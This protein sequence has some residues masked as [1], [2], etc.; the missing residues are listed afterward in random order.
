[1]P[2]HKIGS[3]GMSIKLTNIHDSGMVKCTAQNPYG[4]VNA[5]ANILM[6]DRKCTVY[7]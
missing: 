3:D 2:Q 4:S 1:M 6:Q 7:A 5:Q